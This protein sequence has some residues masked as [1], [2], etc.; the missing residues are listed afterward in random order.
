VGGQV[1]RTGRLMATGILLLLLGAWLV[2]R[3]VAP[4]QDRNLVDLILGKS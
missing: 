4:G 2:L 3:T 1:P